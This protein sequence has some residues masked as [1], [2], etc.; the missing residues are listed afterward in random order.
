MS[1]NNSASMDNLNRQR[2]RR[3]QRERLTGFFRRLA[4]YLALTV[5]SLALYLLP[6]GTGNLFGSE[7]DWYSQ[8]VGAA[9]NLRQM[10]LETGTVFPQYSASGGG[11]SIYDYAYYG[12]LRPDVLFSCLI[13]AV[14]M[15][16][17]ISVYALLSALAAVNFGFCWLKR[18]GLSERAA[19][20]G[21]VIMASAAC[22]FQAH[23]QII[24]VNYLPFLLLAFIGIDLLLEKRKIL[25]L[26]ASIFL[27]CMHS[28]FYAPACLAACLLCLLWQMGRRR[29]ELRLSRGAVLG[30]AA[31][32]A[33]VAVGMAAVLLLP[34]ALNIL[35][36]SKDSGAYSALPVRFVDTRMGGLL[37][38]PYGC[39]LT[40]LS[41]YCLLLSLTKRGKRFLAAALLLCFLLPAASL[42]LNGFLYAR[43]K[44]LIPFL[45]LV[46][47]I[48]ADT[49]QELA[50]KRQK[51]L[52]LPLVLCFV[53]ALTSS[54]RDLILLDGAVLTVW[55]LLLRFA[56][57][58]ERLRRSA[59]AL[60]LLVPICVSF[61]VNRSEDYLRKDDGRQSRFTAGDI[62]M[63]AS[64]DQYRFDVLANNYVNSNVLADGKVW[65]TAMYSS[66]TNGLYADFYYNTMRN[67][68]SLR[69]RVV[70]MP[71]QNSFFSYFMGIRY[72]LAKEDA[73]PRGYTPVFRRGG[74]V[75]AENDEV[76]PICYGTWSLLSEES[77][78]RLNVPARME[79]LCRAAVTEEGGA[80]FRPGA[81]RL[82]LREVFRDVGLAERL[83]SAEGMD[84][85]LTEAAQK[86]IRL[87]KPLHGSALV[88]SFHVESAKGDEVEISVNGMKNNLSSRSAPYPNRNNEFTYVLS[89]DEPL[90]ELEVLCE[91]GRF[92]ISSLQVYAAEL[93]KERTDVAAAVSDGSRADGTTMFSGSVRM[94]QDGYFITS[95]P[96]RKGYEIWVDGERTEGEKV[97]TAFVGFPLKQGSHEIRIAYEAPG[98]AAGLAVSAVSLFTFIVIAGFEI[99][100]RKRKR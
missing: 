94:K 98:F 1:N 60:I 66:V 15:Q 21:A 25:L 76:L 81:E 92:T 90:D 29:E 85:A 75:L 73:L 5:F 45:P 99:T 47:W 44:I 27:I 53:P 40:A 62:T 78:Y 38:S 72:V 82:P 80:A 14:E 3:D 91:K 16:S 95:F 42:A 64:D 59:F 65:K 93:P 13:P 9:E 67:P 17:V 52:L 86:T 50:Q 61:S 51:F 39:G 84:F 26:A 12:L 20:G 23:H 31:L 34:T 28:F 96:Y 7:G 6:V 37:Y 77:F 8:H 24:F 70:L 87:K 30:K 36:T 63:F 18:Q 4:P 88:L 48:C 57:L 69:N 79:A 89:A 100:E 46:V 83:A 71:N 54:W 2:R 49:L 97:N 35:S 22:F 10:M 19:L 33:A 43:G 32:A 74:Y 56:K 55:A 58:P 68:I 11:C 41:L